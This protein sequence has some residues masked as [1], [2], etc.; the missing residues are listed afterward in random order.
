MDYP[1]GYGK[2][3]LWQWVVIYLIIGGLIYA[4]IYYF[5]F[6]N[7]GRSPYGAAYNPRASQTVAQNSVTVTSSGFEPA[8][9]TISVGQTLV[10]YNKGGT[11]VSINSAPHPTHSDY[12]PLNIGLVQDGASATLSFPT[13][14]TYKYHNHLNP[15]QYGTITVQ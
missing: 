8:N 11:A 7:K 13:A 3:P 4:A 14:G 2:R 1:T 12:P 15:S 5:F 9:I 6:A 10:W